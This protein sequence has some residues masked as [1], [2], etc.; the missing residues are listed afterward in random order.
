MRAD[1]EVALQAVVQRDKCV[2][3]LQTP[4]NGSLLPGQTDISSCAAPYYF[5]LGDLEVSAQQAVS[6]GNGLWIAGM[7]GMGLVWLAYGTVVINERCA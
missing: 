6:V 3:M 2:E 7:V 1:C 4:A 5:E